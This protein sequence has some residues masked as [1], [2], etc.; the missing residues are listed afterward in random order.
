MNEH[1]TVKSFKSTMDCLRSE[2]HKRVLVVF[3]GSLIADFLFQ[4]L[5]DEGIMAR[6]GDWRYDGFTPLHFS[7]IC[8]YSQLVD[9]LLASGT[10]ITGLCFISSDKYAALSVA[11]SKPVTVIQLKKH[12]IRPRICCWYWCLKQLVDEFVV[13]GTGVP[14]D[15]K[16]KYCQAPLHLAAQLG[17]DC[18]VQV[19]HQPGCLLGLS[20]I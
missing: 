9:A 19:S 12:H 7:A 2:T 18:L 17:H 3:P 11:F 1:H 10:C 15:V 6:C 16:D 13:I 4:K 14:L 8:G 20:L 5:L